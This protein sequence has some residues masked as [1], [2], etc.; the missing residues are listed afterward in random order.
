MSFAVLCIP[1]QLQYLR[2]YRNYRRIPWGLP[3]GS[4]TV[5][6]FT[7]HTQIP[8][9]IAALIRLLLIGVLTGDHPESV[10]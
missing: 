2:D 6:R 3:R 5:S 1:R 8:A 9:S 4:F 10:G 7:P